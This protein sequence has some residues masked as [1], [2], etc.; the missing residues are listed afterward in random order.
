MTSSL[1]ETFFLISHV[2]GDMLAQQVGD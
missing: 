2:L 1:C